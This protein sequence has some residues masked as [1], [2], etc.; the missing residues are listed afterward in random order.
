M[1]EAAIVGADVPGGAAALLEQLKLCDKVLVYKGDPFDANHS[2]RPDDEVN[3]SPLTPYV[4][5]SES[6]QNMPQSL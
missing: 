6:L 3:L 4:A 2:L 1:A 5:Q